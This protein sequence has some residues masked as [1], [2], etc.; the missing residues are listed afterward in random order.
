M[1]SLKEHRTEMCQVLYDEYN[2]I[3]FQGTLPDVEW[4]FKKMSRSL[5]HANKKPS[6]YVITL[7]VKVF[8][9]TDC[10]TLGFNQTMCAG[11]LPTVLLH[12]M[13]HIYQFSSGNLK[14]PTG[15]FHCMAFY[16]YLE[17]I[18]NTKL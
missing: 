1:V 15:E 7:N 18:R 6:G 11:N 9:T 16:E 17:K 10:K 3:Y 4:K 13:T 14:T 5:G 2:R 8:E 12:E